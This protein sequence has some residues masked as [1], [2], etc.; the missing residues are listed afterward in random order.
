MSRKGSLVSASDF[1]DIGRKDAG[2]SR[3]SSSQD[4][5]KIGIAITFLLISGLILAWYYGIFDTA[6]TL[7]PP[8]PDEIRILDEI[9]A[10]QEA[11]I[12]SGRIQAPS[13]Q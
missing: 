12:K 3:G 13:A 5:L 8:T 7:T 2:T 6:E 10:K 4:K 9:N 11:D 1:G